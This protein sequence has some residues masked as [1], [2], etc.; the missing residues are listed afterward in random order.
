MSSL[1]P[2]VLASL[3]DSLVLPCESAG[4]LKAA[5]SVDIERIINLLKTAAESGSNLRALISAELPEASWQNREE[6]HAVI[7]TIQKL[8]EA[9][10]T[11]KLRSRLLAVATELERGSIVHR[12]AVRVNE[13]NQFRE[14]AINELRSQ[15][16]ME[17]APP[18]LPGPEAEQWI[19]WACGLQ[20]PGDAESLQTLRNGFSHL[21]DF[22]ANLEP[23]LWRAEGSPTLE[24]LPEPERSADKTRQE[25]SRLETN[26]FEKHVVSSVPMPIGLTAAKS[27][28]GC[29]EPRAPHS[30]YEPSLSVL[31]S[32]TLTPNYVTPP[33]TEED[34]E[35][36]QA[37]ERALR[38]SVMDLVTDPARHFNQPAEPSVNAEVFRDTSAA[39]AIANRAVEPPFTAEVFRET[40]ATPAITSDIR[41]RVEQLLQGKWRMPAAALWVLVLV[42]AVVGAVHWWHKAHAGNSPVKAAESA[43]VTP[44]HPENQGYG[45]PGMPA[46][47]ETHTSRPKPETEKQSKPKDQSVAA[48]P[49]SP[50]EPAKKASPIDNAALRLPATIP[51][52]AATV[53]K[54][55]VPPNGAPGVP[56][57]VPDGSPSAPPNSVINIVKDIP[58]AEPKIA[59][60]KVAVSSGVAQGLL[61]HQ[62]APQYPS[63]AKQ[64]GIEGTVVLQAV[65][66]EDGTV[67]N[68]HA[69]GGNPLLVQ[70]AVDAVK[71]WRY[72]PYA[73]NGKP[74]EADTQI[75]VKFT[76][77]Q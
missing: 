37:Q 14:Q 61:V 51:K 65:I 52:N 50:A 28:G 11:E 30:F 21:D 74:V 49:P 40:S 41:T 67:H 66:G 7:E 39:P 33:R 56:G 29:D 68:V 60:Q 6:L 55:D 70:A 8:E 5:Q 23:N 35:R 46:D 75:I 44:S 53:N 54:E 24:V 18:T 3:D 12:R 10:K 42:L 69:L 62:V 36:M 20:E 45:Q 17:G 2:S 25:Q 26:G 1:W 76:P 73:L 19:E 47:S 57:S 31:E 43:D 48:K 59:P 13:L 77:H 58:V 64:A 32:D 9:R 34:V 72:K 38:A 22:I 27:S 71:Q 16:E 63:Q 15:A 4:K